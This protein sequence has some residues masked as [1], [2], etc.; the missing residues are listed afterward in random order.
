MCAVTA[1]AVSASAGPETTL[2]RRASMG[3]EHS[4]TVT[5]RAHEPEIHQFRKGAYDYDFDYLA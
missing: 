1:V 3:F 5:V 2:S 4:Q